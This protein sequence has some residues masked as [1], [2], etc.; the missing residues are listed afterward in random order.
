MNSATNKLL[1]CVSVDPDDNPCD[2][3]CLR[4]S[5]LVDIGLLHTPAGLALRSSLAELC[6]HWRIKF[7]SETAICV[8]EFASLSFQTLMR[9]P[10]NLSSGRCHDCSSKETNSLAESGLS[11]AVVCILAAFCSENEQTITDL[12]AC[13]CRRCSTTCHQVF[14]LQQV[15][16]HRAAVRAHGADAVA[17]VAGVTLSGIGNGLSGGGH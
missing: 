11:C 5:R 3:K 15:S 12:C 17:A 4:L 6:C 14:A 10:P 1:T 13:P 7:W 16:R 2:F 9:S 8:F